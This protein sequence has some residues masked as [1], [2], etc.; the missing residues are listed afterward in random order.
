MRIAVADVKA[1]FSAYL[2]TSEDG[3]VIVNETARHLL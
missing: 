2:K 3:P 1:Y